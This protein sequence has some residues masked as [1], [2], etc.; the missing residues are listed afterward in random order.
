MRL[1]CNLRDIMDQ[2]GITVSALHDASHVGVAT[3]IDLRRNTWKQI[4]QRSL[5]ALCATL[6]VTL[7]ELFE[8]IPEDIWAPIKMSREVTIHYGSRALPDPPDSP[9]GK[10]GPVRQFIG[11]WDQ[12]AINLISDYLHES[13]P[14]VRVRH[15][16]HITGDHG[17]DPVVRDAAQRVFH[18][19]NHVLIGSPVANGFAEQVICHAYDVAPGA[20]AMQDRFPYGFVWESNRG[21]SSSF[22]REDDGNEIGIWS[23]GT[24]K[25][26]AKRTA[27]RSG[28]GEDCALILVYRTWQ[29]PSRRSRGGDNERVVIALLGHSGVGTYA[30]TQLAIDPVRAV[31]L[32][33]T[34]KKKPLMRAVRATYNCYP[35]TPPRDNRQVTSGEL[36]REPNEAAIPET[37]TRDEK[38]R[39][40]KSKPG[41]RRKSD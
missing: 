18:E 31:G 19:G 20:G 2:R 11:V 36:V 30:A 26:V 1:R 12:R 5:A 34:E 22:G 39:S 24:G 38:P 13:C 9:D 10:V 29:P 23:T 4:R 16:E 3:I 17:F 8:L 25:L 21:V 40:P 35:V 7:D 15:E 27:V 6:N 32:F 41:R 33:P 14:D 28:K 37:T